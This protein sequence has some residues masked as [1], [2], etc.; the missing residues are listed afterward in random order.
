MEWLLHTL[1][2]GVLANEEGI[3]FVRSLREVCPVWRDTCDD[4]FNN[5]H[6]MRPSV[7]AGF[8]FVEEQL[9]VLLHNARQAMLDH[10]PMLN[11]GLGHVYQ[12][13][14]FPVFREQVAR[15]V[16][17]SAMYSSDL[18]TQARIMHGLVSLFRD[19]VI[20]LHV[21]R[22]MED[23]DYSMP[24]VRAVL[25]NMKLYRR[26]YDMMMLCIQLLRLL[27]RNRNLCESIGVTNGAL[28]VLLAVMNTE[29]QPASY[30]PLRIACYNVLMGLCEGHMGMKG[31]VYELGGV[32][33]LR[34]VMRADLDFTA[35]QVVRTSG[36]F[37]EPIRPL[38]AHT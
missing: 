6:W 9:H 26:E 18:P 22:Y 24:L 10:N 15:I 37:R 12:S 13:G 19:P 36:Q 8:V 23:L 31:H 16:Q 7:T 14:F 27:C 2:H 30:A 33:I 1:Q 35:I 28:R 5:H 4:M 32:P 29:G 38:I 21:R 11:H 17:A 25:K 34:Q 20:V 3:A